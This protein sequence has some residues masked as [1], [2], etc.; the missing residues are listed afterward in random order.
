MV[1]R[2]TY[3]TTRLAFAGAGSVMFAFV[4][5]S[6]ISVRKF[7]YNMFPATPWFTHT[8][9]THPNNMIYLLPE[10]ENTGYTQ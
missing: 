3:A 10:D 1:S 9:T 7:L 8:Q 5:L 4:K 6:R 2:T